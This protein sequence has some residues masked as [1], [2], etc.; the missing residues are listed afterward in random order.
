MLQ[1]E[2]IDPVYEA[3]VQATEEAIINALL[4][5]ETMTGADDLRVPALPHERMRAILRKYRRLP[6]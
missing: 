2:R 6:N 1:D 5:A 3:T 4:A